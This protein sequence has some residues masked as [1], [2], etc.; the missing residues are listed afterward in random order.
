MKKE[1]PLIETERLILREVT[2]EDAN[3]LFKYLSDKDV[4][5]HM[6]LAPFQTVKDIW[7]EI[8]WYNS[9]RGTTM[10]VPQNNIA[11][12]SRISHDLLWL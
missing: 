1:F 12:S 6:G 8:N 5:K 10:A 9:I 7:D 11:I 3:D 4:V 2:T